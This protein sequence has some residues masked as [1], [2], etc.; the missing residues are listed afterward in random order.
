MPIR[1]PIANAASNIASLGLST[2]IGARAPAASIASPNAEQVNRMPAAPSANAVFRQRNDAAR[3]RLGQDAVALAVDAQANH[4][5]YWQHSACGHGWAN[6]CCTGSIATVTAWIN[7]MRV[8][9]PVLWGVKATIK[10]T[11]CGA[12]R[13]SAHAYR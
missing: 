3:H 4:P 5:G 6:A 11:L 8:V 13:P 2:G 9:I 7:A 10:R 1:Q 12:S